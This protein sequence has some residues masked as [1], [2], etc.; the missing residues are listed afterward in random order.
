MESR[1]IRIHFD[2]LY[3]LAKGSRPIHTALCVG[4]VPPEIEKIWSRLRSAGVVVELFERGQDSGREQGADQCLQVHMLRAALD[5]P[6]GIAVLVTGDGAGYENGVGFHAD[7]ERLHKRGWGIE[8][9]SW[10]H[11]CNKRLRNWAEKVGV[12]ISLEKFYEQV[13]FVQN[14]RSA[15]PLNLKRRPFTS[16]NP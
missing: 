8:V 6:P 16:L 7:L 2:N 14:G 13:T 4:T 1:A 11:S 9:I 3:A 15:S 10:E 12:F 5:H